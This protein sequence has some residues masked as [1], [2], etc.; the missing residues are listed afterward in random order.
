MLAA[1]SAASG[2]EPIVTGKPHEPMAHL[3]LSRCAGVEP[4]S[5]LMVGDK[6][7]TDGLFAETIGCPFALV[8]TGV[9]PAGSAPAGVRAY[10]DLASVV[11]EVFG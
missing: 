4:Q 10:D 7:S 2:R 8:M 1:I 9:T 11:A 5:M 6:V 3:V